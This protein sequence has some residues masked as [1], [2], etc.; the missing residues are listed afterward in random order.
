[1]K[2]KNIFVFK[3]FMNLKEYK[4]W[5]REN[6]FN[7]RLNGK[8]L[9]YFMD[10]AEIED[11]FGKKKP[12]I[13][14]EIETSLSSFDM[15]KTLKITHIFHYLGEK[16]ITPDYFLDTEV[17]LDFIKKINRDFSY[18][19]NDGIMEKILKFKIEPMMKS[20]KN[21]V[22]NF[23]FIKN[24]IAKISLAINSSK[25]KNI[26]KYFSLREKQRN[27]INMSDLAFI[28]ID[29]FSNNKISLKTYTLYSSLADC[30]KNEKIKNK[31]ELDVINRNLNAD[32]ILIMKKI[33][34]SNSSF[35]FGGCYFCF[36]KSNYTSKESKKILYLKTVRL[37]TV[38]KK[39]LQNYF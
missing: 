10:A 32:Y 19:F 13:E 23:D 6:N 29:F 33:N 31:Q 39:S 4:N 15:G 11:K 21:L 18:N 25:I 38:Y 3:I 30:F 14:Y 20:E 28:N 34:Q 26:Y 7:K 22:I 8:I 2:Q 9:S 27:A 37:L 5:V 17:F 24:A 12:D 36:D 35:D 16:N 1:M